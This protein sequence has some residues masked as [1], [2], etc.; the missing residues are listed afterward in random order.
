MYV[1]HGTKIMLF[2]V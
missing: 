2:L 1:K